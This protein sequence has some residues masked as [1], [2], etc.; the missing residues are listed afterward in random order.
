MKKRILLYA[1]A[2]SCIQMSFAQ[3]NSIWLTV[4]D[5]F[6]NTSTVSTANT[7]YYLQSINDSMAIRQIGYSTLTAR[8]TIENA[9]N[10]SVG[11]SHT[12]AISKKIAIEYG[13]GLNWMRF[14]AI[15]DNDNSK[16][17]FGDQ[18][19]TILYSTTKFNNNIDKKITYINPYQKPK[20]GVEYVS[21]DLILP[22]SLK[23]QLSKAFGIAVGAEI[24]SSLFAKSKI[25][26]NRSE[27]VSENTEEIVYKNV[28]T[29]EVNT[30]TQAIP[31]FGVSGVIQGQLSITAN[32]TIALGVNYRL[33]R[34][35]Q[36]N[37]NN[38]FFIGQ[39]THTDN[40]YF[41]VYLK[42]AYSW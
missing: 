37:R 27:K 2:L 8:T 39:A 35:L 25:E 5:N 12:H 9:F 38:S 4:G 28:L 7:G 42:Y 32:Q 21:M 29:S 22:I 6:F 11:I 41:R 24:N 36:E 16:V 40:K 19:D 3:K 20:N 10:F 34:Q 15:T 13:I 14:T 17:V 23:Y 30:N 26:A 1:L 31:R 33:T 18:M